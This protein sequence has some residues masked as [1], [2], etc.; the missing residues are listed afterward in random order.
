MIY[1]NTKKLLYLKFC[2]IERNFTI[3][4]CKKKFNKNIILVFVLNKSGRSWTCFKNNNGECQKLLNSCQ[5]L[6]PNRRENYMH[7]FW[8]YSML[9]LFLSCFCDRILYIK[10]LYIFSCLH[11][12]LK[13]SFFRLIVPFVPICLFKRTNWNWN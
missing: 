2:W 5:I 9:F 4:N 11:V 1:N 13:I 7:L 8:I 3:N 12:P 10:L 6:M